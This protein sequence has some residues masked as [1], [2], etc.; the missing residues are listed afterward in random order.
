MTK[1]LSKF[2]FVFATMLAPF[3]ANIFAVYP[4]YQNHFL[5]IYQHSLYSTQTDGQMIEL[6][7]GSIWKINYY[8]KNTVQYWRTGDILEISQTYNSFGRDRFWISNK[9]QGSYV[10][11]ELSLGP[12]DTNPITNHLVYADRGIVSIMTVSGLES[13]YVVDSRDAHLLSTWQLDNAIIVG[14]NNVTWI[15]FFEKSDIILINVDQ[16]NY[17]RATLL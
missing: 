11:A 9:T 8:H 4:V 6:D 16:N 10:Q 5:P 17:V 1:S 14:V 13:R 7:D 2:L 3:T 15:S 12:I